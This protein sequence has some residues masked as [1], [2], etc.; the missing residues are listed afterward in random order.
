M[1][2]EPPLS[3]DLFLV[4]DRLRRKGSDDQTPCHRCPPGSY[5]ALQCPQVVVRDRRIALLKALQELLCIRVRFLI[6]P[7]LDHRPGLLE[8]I[9]ASAPCSRFSLGLS[10]G[11]PHLASLPRCREAFAESIQAGF[12]RLDLN[13]AVDH[14]KSG[15]ATLK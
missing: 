12:T 7:S 9:N 5:P 2:A 11:W 6:E 3:F 10:V 14:L 1:G 8:G 13:V 4:A 15:K